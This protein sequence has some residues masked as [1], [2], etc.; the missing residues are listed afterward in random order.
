MKPL[1]VAV[2]LLMLACV[3]SAMALILPDEYA[4]RKVQPGMTPADVQRL[5]G[6]P[7]AIR[8]AEGMFGPIRCPKMGRATCLFFRRYLH[9]SVFV[10]VG[11]NGRVECVDRSFVT[12]YR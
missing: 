8:P 3:I 12:L 11:P 2:M 9:E 7:T 5:I 10:F 6:R 4:I 1:F